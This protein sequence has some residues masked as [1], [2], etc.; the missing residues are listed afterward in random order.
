MELTLKIALV[1]FAL[2]W[3]LS[4]TVVLATLVYVLVR[5]VRILFKD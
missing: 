5:T 4:I 2:V 1:M 3:L